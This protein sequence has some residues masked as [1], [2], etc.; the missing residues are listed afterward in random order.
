M[1]LIAQNML[2][3]NLGVTLRRRPLRHPPQPDEVPAWPGYGW[4]SPGRFSLS[5]TCRGVS[6]MTATSRAPNSPAGPT[7][8]TPS[9]LAESTSTTPSSLAEPTSGPSNSPSQPTSRALN[10]L[11]RP[12]SRTPNSYA[13]PASHAPSSPAG[14]TSGALSSTTSSARPTGAQRPAAAARPTSGTPNSPAGPTSEEPSS[15][16][17][18]T[19]WAHGW[20]QTP[21]R[22][23]S[24]RRAGRPD[25]LTQTTGKILLSGTSP[26]W[27]TAPTGYMILSV[28][29]GGTPR[30]AIPRVRLWPMRSGGSDKAA[31]GTGMHHAYGRCGLSRPSGLRPPSPLRGSFSYYCGRRPQLLAIG[32]NARL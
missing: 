4:N 31:P 28:G 19:S 3:R 1:R 29:K 5:L 16:A 14:P 20:P 23:A 27:R 22:A 2:R 13:G 15:P 8:T 12:T 11:A 10:S 6:S 17:K 7:S 9:S 18:S 24:G 21:I 26:R 25:P 32:S 30:G